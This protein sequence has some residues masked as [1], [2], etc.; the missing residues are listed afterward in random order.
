M[1]WRCAGGA[2]EVRRRCA[3]GALEVRRRCAGGALLGLDT[4]LVRERAREWGWGRGFSVKVK[5]YTGLWGRGG[6]QL[7]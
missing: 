2:P 7:R 3:G 6:L 4:S 5:E 1:R